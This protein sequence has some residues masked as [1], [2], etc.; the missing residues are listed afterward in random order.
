MGG[1]ADPGRAGVLLPQLRAGPHRRVLSRSGRR[2]RVRTGPATPGTRSPP[3]T[4]GSSV[5]ADDVEALLVRVPD[6]PNDAP[7]QCYLVPIDACYEFVGRLRMLWRGFDGG[8]EAREFIDEFFAPDRG[9]Q[10]DRGGVHADERRHLRR[11]RRRPRTVR[12]DPGAHRARRRRRQWA[13]IPCTRSRCACQV[14][15]EPLRRGY[16]DDEADGLTDLFGP[17]ERWANTQRTFLWQHSTAMVPG[18]H[19]QPPR[20]RCRWSAPTTS[21]SPRPNTCTR[22]ATAAIPLQFLFSGTIFT[23]GQSGFSVQQ[24]PW[25]R[26]DH[27]DMPVAVWRDLVARSTTRT[28]GGCGWATTPS[29]A[30]AAYKS[31]RGLLDL[32]DAVDLAAGQRRRRGRRCR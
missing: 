22:C 10:Q 1:A 23:R 20:S 28:A 15:I 13:T 29:T 31:A 6:D 26:E 5:L 16:T 3:P 27:Y 12:G 19:R 14:R 4:P 24:V 9:A 25:D 18:V 8:Q 30:L 17:R 21:R 11:A 7:P 2:H 32:D